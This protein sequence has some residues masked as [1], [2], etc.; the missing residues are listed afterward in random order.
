MATNSITSVLTILSDAM[1]GQVSTATDILQAHGKDY[2]WHRP[3]APEAVCFPRSNEEVAL[4]V[5]TCGEHGVPIIPFGAGSSLEGGVLATRGGVSVDLTQMNKILNV[6]VADMDCTVQ[7]GVRRL[8]LNERLAADGMFFPVDPGANATLGG[9]TATRASG[10]NAVRYGTMRENVVSLKVVLADG[11]IIETGTRARKSAAGY[12]LTRL[13]VGSEGTLG[14]ITEV[15]LRMQRI[16]ARIEAAVIRFPDISSAIDVV[17]KT[18]AAGIRMAR[19][20]LL[21]GLMMQGMNLYSNLQ[22]PEQPTLFL[23]FNGSP[24]EVDDQVRA[25]RQLADRTVNP[26]AIGDGFEQAA[27]PAERERLWHARH[28]AYHSSIALRPGCQVMSSDV[29]VPMSKL[30]ACVQAVRDDVAR[31]SIIAPLVG[32]IGEGNFHMQFLVDPENDAEIAEAR[33]L[34]E[35]LVNMALSYGG[36][37]TGEHGVG[38]GKR[39]YLEAEY[40]DAFG[41][42]KNIKLALDPGNIMNPGKVIALS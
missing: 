9:M 35:R 11:Q 29:C 32:H 21:D 38:I 41:L 4:I 7:G 16:P 36:T 31:S 19:I 40:G 5:K 30:N 24:S 6:S 12:D 3:A 8:Q 18:H 37:C 28:H 20:E 13:F 23:E 17:I 14:I 26:D 25:F 10:T 33:L 15:T 27:T 2:S 22:Y 39:K 42:L 1:P 34:H